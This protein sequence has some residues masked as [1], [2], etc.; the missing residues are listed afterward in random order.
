METIIR[1][2][3]LLSRVNYKNMKWKN[4]R[5]E[6]S[7]IARFP[8]ED[9]FLWRLSMAPVVENGPF[10]L[11]PGYDR[12][13]TLVEGKGLRIKDEVVHFGEVIKFSGDENISGELI[14]GKII[15]LN[16]I[17][18]RNLVQVKY[19]VLKLSGKPYSFYKGVG[20]AF[21]FGLS[22]ELNISIGEGSFIVKEKDTLQ[23]DDPK[24]QVIIISGKGS[25]VLVEL[26]WENQ[27]RFL[28]RS[29]A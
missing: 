22:G 16:L 2:P 27:N 20:V 17:V 15:D 23:M 11:F 13:L 25:F 28:R 29:I 9:P 6:T 4:G 21:I 19:E 18:R 3:T 14:D 5:G 26:N 8:E 12:Y 10:S 1:M 7:E 24:G